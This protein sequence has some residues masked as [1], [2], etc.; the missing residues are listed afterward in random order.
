MLQQK[1]IGS[2]RGKLLVFGGVYSNLQALEAIKQV[3]EREGIAPTSI[4]CT[5]DIVG[6]CAEP[7]ACI[8]L[9]KDW[10]IHSIAGNVELN[11]A[12]GV[13]DCGCNFDDG[14][15][16]DLLSRQWYPYAQ[17]QLS[18]A[19]IKW[20]NMLPLY[21]TFEFAGEKGMVVHG[22]YQDIARFVFASTDWEEKAA[23]FA[24][25]QTDILLS[26]HC[27]LPFSQQ[28]DGKSWLNAG[29]IGMPANDG[30]PRV[31]YMILEETETG[32]VHQHKNLHYDH[33]TAAH[34]MR[35]RPLPKS[36]ALTLETGIWD[37]MDI[38][39]PTEAALQ[40]IP[41]EPTKLTQTFQLA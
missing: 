41:L 36:Y 32:W 4:I 31:W 26:G 29:V 17:S 40:G 23:Q 10:G 39:P 33:L 25:T 7:E 15:R 35:G 30:T 9:V 14:S 8:Q 13:E 6:Y 28:K 5:G 16:C 22:A 19:S 2:L 20:I 3:A 27:G 1:H 12:D 18:E 11:L 34:M 37:N 38:L 24:L 21:L